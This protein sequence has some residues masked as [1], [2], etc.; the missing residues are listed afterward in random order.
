MSVVA[1][2]VVL[3]MAAGDVAPARGYAGVAEVPAADGTAVEPRV[4][5]AKP[6][7]VEPAPAA[8]SPPPPRV[9]YSD[10]PTLD[11]RRVVLQRVGVAVV[12][13][14]AAAYVA[15]IV[16]MGVGAATKGQIA[17]LRSRD[18]IDRRRQLVDRGVIANK[19]AL[20]AGI[21]GAIAIVAGAIMIGVARRRGRPR[22]TT[23]GR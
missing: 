23:A 3:A 21:S 12:V 14:G 9:V 17:S 1:W 20:G 4:V 16:G 15:M 5:E 6:E 19:L 22:S 2:I 11:H 18:E 8:E 7:P 13:L 10:V